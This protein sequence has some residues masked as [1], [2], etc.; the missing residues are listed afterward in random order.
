MELCSKFVSDFV[1]ALIDVGDNPGVT[2][3]IPSYVAC[4][5]NSD[6]AN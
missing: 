4:A 2:L 3:S 6:I 5:K 1:I